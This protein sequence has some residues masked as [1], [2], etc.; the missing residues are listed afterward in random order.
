MRYAHLYIQNQDTNISNRLV[1]LL[2]MVKKKSRVL[3]KYIEWDVHRYWNTIL[4]VYFVSGCFHH[5]DH[6]H[7]HE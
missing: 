5:L 7:K 2:S 1:D 3:R 6:F 4:S